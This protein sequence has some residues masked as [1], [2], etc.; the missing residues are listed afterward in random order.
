MADS[1]GIELHRT[2]EV[3]RETVA[4]RRL[5]MSDAA[6]VHEAFASAGDMARQGDVTTA[7]GAERYVARLLE[8]GSSHEAWA[9]V[10]ADELIGLISVT[11]DEENRSGWLWY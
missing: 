11:V 3:R 1:D 4:L 8:A 6:A 7:E 9:I 2:G 10:E 5:R